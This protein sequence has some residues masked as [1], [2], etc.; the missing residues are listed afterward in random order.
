MVKPVLL[1]VDDETEVLSAITR[2]LRRHYADHY[3]IMRA[4]SGP[5][6]LDA[7]HQLYQRNEPV[8]LL[9]VDQRMPHMSGVELL[10][11]AMQLYPD[12]RRVL[13]TAYADTNAAI[14]A[15]NA[16]AV[17]YYLLK[18][19]DPP[20]EML[21]PV[22]DDLLEDWRANYRPPFEGIRI[23]SHRWSAHTHRLKEFLA[24]NHVPYQYLDIELHDQAQQLLQ[25]L[26]LDEITFPLML[27]EDGNVLCNPTITQ[28]ADSIGL[29]TQAGQPFYDLAIVGGG[30]AGL[31]AA[32]YGASE[33]LST[34]M[35][36]R[37][38]PGG[39][40]GTSSRIENYLGFPAGL[41]GADLARRATTQARRFGVEILISQEATGIR[42]E[43]PYHIL[44][45][46][47]GSEIACHA[48]VIAVGLTYRGLDVAGIEPLIG[49]GIYYGASLTEALSCQ[50]QPVCTIGAGNSAGQAALYLA[51]HAS[52]LTMLVRG[53]SLEAKMS[54]YLV[55]RIHATPNIEVKLH[56]EMIGVQGTDHLEC[57]TLRNNQTGASETRPM[58]AAFIFTGAIPCTSW[59]REVVA[60]DP[61]GFVLT[62][63]QI[64][65]NDTY[66]TN[67]P[68]ERPPF[69][70]E[71]SVPGIFAVGDV[72]SGSIKRVASAVGEGAIAV[73]FVH[74]Y[75]SQM[76]EI[77]TV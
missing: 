11:Q 34:V 52:H 27:C 28:I 58:S 74:E 59:L 47:D 54:Q 30:P 29:S 3:R 7:L 18:P 4:D 66:R 38:A 48:L 17:H 63:P 72:R 73:K 19:W 20:E 14:E 69:L 1:S 49:A 26:S 13:L 77:M 43:G 31:G 61:H 55:E 75:L 24:R 64:L 36:E 22:L 25:Q 12:A 65:T 57:I 6:A 33:G 10:A 44:T 46:A 9:L 37:E 62:G 15:I 8:A 67:W 60:C 5:A 70:L 35:I 40:A 68:L 23:I 76:Q 56:T 45:L 39:Q 16:A 42:R 41:S 21:Y 32:V 2:D 50:N 71:T 51:G 53:D